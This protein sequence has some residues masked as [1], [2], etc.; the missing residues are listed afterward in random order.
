M[1]KYSAQEK[2]T[3]QR[4]AASTYHKGGKGPEGYLLDRS[5]SGQRAKVYY[6][7]KTKKTII[8]HRGSQGAK[9]WLVSDAA[10]VADTAF[11]TKLQQKTKRY[12]YAERIQKAAEKKYAGTDI[13]TTGHSLGGHLARTAGKKGKVVT[14]NSGYDRFHGGSVKNSQEVNYRNQN[15]LVSKFTHNPSNTISK[16]TKFKGYI[17]AHKIGSS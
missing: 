3:L 13:T 15:D 12:K 9:D 11:G 10:L 1:V 6:N 4:A 16:K 2:K 7:P 8:A 14:F 17:N 5:L